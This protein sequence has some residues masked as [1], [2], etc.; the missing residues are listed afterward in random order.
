MIK[1]IRYTRSVYAIFWEFIAD[2]NELRCAVYHEIEG[3]NVMEMSR[4]FTFT[5]GMACIGSAWVD[6][7][8]TL[9]KDATKLDIKVFLRANLILNDGVKQIGFTRFPNGVL[10][11]GT[12]EWWTEMQTIDTDEYGR[13]VNDFLE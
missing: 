13:H 4:T 7:T 6:P 8:Y 2:I 11:F 3:R 10:E 12:T 5:P 9:I 1:V